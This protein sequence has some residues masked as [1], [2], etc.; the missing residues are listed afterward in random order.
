G[1]PLLG[2]E[3]FCPQCGA[4]VK[5]PP[6]PVPATPA[7]HVEPPPPV[8]PQPEPTVVEAESIPIVATPDDEI[9]DLAEDDVGFGLAQPLDPAEPAT[10]ASR[11]HTTVFAP[12][13]GPMGLGMLAGCLVFVIIGLALLGIWQGRNLRL[14]RQA[15]AA[16]EHYAQGID[17]MDQGNYE[18]AIAEF[19]YA[20]RLRPTY[21]DAERKLKEAEAKA[22]QQPTPTVVGA[23]GEPSALLADG[24]I[25]YE[26]GAWSEAILK[27][28]A[29]QA[30]DAAYEQ[31]TVRRLL[32][33]AYTNEGLRLVNE[34]SMEEA[35]R[36]FDQALALEPGNTDVQVQRRLAALYQSGLGAW[37]ADWQEVINS[38]SALY[39]LKPDYKDTAQRLQRAYVLAGDSAGTQSNWCDA[40]TYYKAAL[41]MSSTPELAAKRDEAASLCAAPPTSGTPA[42]SGTFIGVMV[43]QEP[44]Q[45]TFGKV[46]G[47]VTDA[48]GQPVAGAAVKLSAYDWSVTTN[49]DGSGYYVFEALDK[50]ITFAVTLV[51][52]PAQPVDVQVTLST[53]SMVNF[54][55]KR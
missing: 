2:T 35:I 18:L 48:Q 28:A 30:A 37:E 3:S 38:L 53:A 32:V 33:G 1:L 23:V 39:A 31:A 55:E 41:I 17:Y 43:K 7:R 10:K 22:K 44:V 26:R 8:A 51:G 9:V 11:G 20:L 15:D 12:I 49:T 27:L 52:L 21:P 5:K 14:Q 29:L 47:T 42:P 45:G 36:R 40:V 34:G 16:A 19:E 46:H 4:A 13:A 50:E 54:Q 24:R 25:A 6:R